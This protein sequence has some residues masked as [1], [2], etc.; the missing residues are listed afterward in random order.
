MDMVGHQ[1]IGMNAAARLARVLGQPVQ[2]DAVIVLGKE[3]GLAVV[4]ALYQVQRDAR[5]GKAG[6]T[7]HGDR[8]GKGG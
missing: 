7:R 4:A 1:H 6:A 2:V 5:Q 8:K 3:T